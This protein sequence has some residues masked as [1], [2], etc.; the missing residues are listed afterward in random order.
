MLKYCSIYFFQVFTEKNLS[1]RNSPCS[2]VA[3]ACLS[4]YNSS[5]SSEVF[6]A[7]SDHIIHTVRVHIFL[8]VENLLYYF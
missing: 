7:E 8:F 5:S 4:R 6:L 1:S 3:S 2:F